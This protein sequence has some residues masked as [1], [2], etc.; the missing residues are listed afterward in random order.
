LPKNPNFFPSGEKISSG[1]VKK[2]WVDPLPTT[3]QKYAWVGSVQG[4]A[5]I[6][7]QGLIY[8]FTFKSSMLS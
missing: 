8:L 3:G 5:L 4:A 1:R 7:M 6:F 2:R